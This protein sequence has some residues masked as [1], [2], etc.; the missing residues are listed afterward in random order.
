MSASASA[1]ASRT[2]SVGFRPCIDIHDGRVKQVVGSTLSDLGKEDS[3]GSALLTNFS[4]DLGGA[5]YANLYAANDLPGGHVI[6]L[7]ANEA[8]RTQ[9]LEALGA[10]P[11]GLQLGGGV[12]TENAMEYIDAGAS[13]VIVTS[14][15]F[16]DGRLLVVFD[17]GRE[18]SRVAGRRSRGDPRVCSLDFSPSTS[19]TVPRIPRFFHAPPTGMLDEDRLS[20]LVS[21]V[22]KSRIVLDLSCR[23][24]PDAKYYVVTDRW[25]KFS[26]LAV[27][28]GTLTALA[29]RC[30]EFL[31]HGVDVEGK[32]LGIDDELVG[33]LGRCTPVPST[34]AGGASTLEDLD[35]VAAMGGGRVEVTVGSALDIFGGGLKFDDVVAWHRRVAESRVG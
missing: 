15:V 30:D 29:D 16:R 27:D 4:S 24:K 5:Y 3:A 18:R 19:L 34:Y 31:V 9:A 14:Y 8:S 12:T 17:E 10:Y 7:G 20:S 2:P 11:G 6:M 33:L 23:K 1:S 22:G 13:H 26:E 35:R 25:Q 21:L 28:E 32:K